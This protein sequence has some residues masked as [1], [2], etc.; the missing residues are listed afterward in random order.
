MSR[1]TQT[2]KEVSLTL[3]RTVD[4]SQAQKD[5]EPQT[6]RVHIVRGLWPASSSQI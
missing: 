5:Q 3:R 4:Q 2:Q 6:Q 1:R